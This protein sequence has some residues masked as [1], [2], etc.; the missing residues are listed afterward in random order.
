MGEATQEEVQEAGNKA[1]YWQ[2]AKDL[3][4]KGEDPLVESSNTIAYL[5]ATNQHDEAAINLRL[6]ATLEAMMSNPDYHKQVDAFSYPTG[7]G[8]R[9]DLSASPGAHSGRY[10][11]GVLNEIDMRQF[12]SARASTEDA[13][14]A[15]VDAMSYEDGVSMITRAAGDA[16]IVDAPIVKPTWE[17]DTAPGILKIGPQQ[18]PM[19]QWA[20]TNWSH[21]FTQEEKELMRDIRIRRANTKWGTDSSG[22]V[23]TPTRKKAAKI[24][25]GKNESRDFVST[26]HSVAIG[27]GDMYHVRTSQ[28][29]SWTPT[30]QAG[31]RMVSNVGDFPFSLRDKIVTTLMQGKAA[32]A[33]DVTGLHKELAS[34]ANG[35]RFRD[36][37][38]STTASP[39]E[40]LK[41]RMAA[42]DLRVS[43]P[44]LALGAAYQANLDT[45]TIGKL[46]DLLDAGH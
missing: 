16:D 22:A 39:K 19:P 29:D 12:I 13:G 44:H 7:A 40:W 23:V 8:L 32:S 17:G 46:L 36:G 20:G 5:R 24:S 26:D 11:K 18:E 30:R 10:S 33:E 27:V 38:Y 45:K 31:T 6:Q 43:H 2:T 25:F 42:R 4:N 35:T 3:V 1:S 41:M 34:M 14:A 21:T 28:F 37:S 15:G 9:P